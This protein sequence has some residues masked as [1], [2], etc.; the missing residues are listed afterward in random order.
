MST[1]KDRKIRRAREGKKEQWKERRRR[2]SLEKEEQ[3]EAEA[4]FKTKE[5]FF[6]QDD[7]SSEFF[8]SEEDRKKAEEAKTYIGTCPYNHICGPCKFDYRN[9]G[10]YNRWQA[11][12]K[13]VNK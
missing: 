9:C 4:E 12:A 8:F 13:A 7:E 10:S 1:K 11:R 5:S 2:E 3:E 6:Y